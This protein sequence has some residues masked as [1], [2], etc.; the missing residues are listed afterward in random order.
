LALMAVKCGALPKETWLAERNK[1][2]MRCPGD[3]PGLTKV[4][5]QKSFPEGAMAKNR[6][7]TAL[8][9]WLEDGDRPGGWDILTMCLSHRTFHTE[10]YCWFTDPNIAFEFKLRWV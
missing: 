4:V 8:T 7:T 5:F 9:E 1:L 10:Y 2:G 6:W 3:Y